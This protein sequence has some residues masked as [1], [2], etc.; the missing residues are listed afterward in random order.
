MECRV[1]VHVGE[2]AVRFEGLPD[3]VVVAK[4]VAVLRSIFGDPRVPEV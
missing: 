3:D 2:D 4:A 1:H